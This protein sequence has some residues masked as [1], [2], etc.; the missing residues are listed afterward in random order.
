MELYGNIPS[1]WHLK[2]VK[3]VSVTYSGGTPPRADESFYH[4]NIPWVKSSELKEKYLYDTEEKINEK[5]IRNSSTRYVEADTVLF[6]LYGATSGDMTIL[7]I[8]A[9]M[10]QAVLC[11]PIIEKKKYNTEFLFYALKF[12]TPKLIEISQGGGQP[13][14]TKGIIDKTK[15]L[16][17]KKAEEQQY[18]A[19]ILTKVDEAIT[20]TK[21][22]IAKAERLK[23]SLVQNLLSGK[24][25]ADG[26]WRKE[27]EFY[28]DEKFGNTPIGWH[29]GRLSE[30]ADVI[31]GQSPAGEFYNDEGKGIPML[32][33]P[34]EFTDHHPIPVQYTTKRTKLC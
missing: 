20:T 24:L 14:L 32:N 25:K 28:K 33:G 8:K 22:T 21:E 18:I 12:L 11:I 27:K 31:A 7:K 16:F 2:K 10:N 13:N 19:D 29:W 6:A 23:K 5:A 9:C 4:G 26:S 34:T 1:G 3:E 17:P 30:I 15:I